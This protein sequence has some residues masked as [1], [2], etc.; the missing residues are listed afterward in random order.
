MPAS[1]TNRYLRKNQMNAV[2]IRPT[3]I[4]NAPAAAGPIVNK[5]S[6]TGLPSECPA[7]NAFNVKIKSAMLKRLN[8]I[9]RSI[10]AERFSRK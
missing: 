1:K 8:M 9:K 10:T 6:I 3:A 2:M 5:R 7:D 4:L